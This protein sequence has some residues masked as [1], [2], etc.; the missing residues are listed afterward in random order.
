MLDGSVFFSSCRLMLAAAP[1]SLRGYAIF[2]NFTAFFSFISLVAAW[3]LQL[4]SVS[5]DS[6]KPATAI[7]FLCIIRRRKIRTAILAQAGVQFVMLAPMLAAPREMNANVVG[8][9]GADWTIS[10]CVMLHIFG[11]FITGLF[12]AYLQISERFGLTPT[13]GLGLFL[14]ATGLSVAI[15]ESNTWNIYVALALIGVGWNVV[16]VAG[17]EL[18]L[19]S[20]S[21]EERMKVTAVNE[22][23]R[24]IA[25]IISILLASSL[26]WPVLLRVCSASVIVVAFVIGS[27]PRELA[28]N[29]KPVSQPPMTHKVSTNN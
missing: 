13:M 5:P 20:H 21:H 22:C 23:L 26:A 11:M 19:R 12:T 7:S 15:L 2:F 17:T 1:A 3:G 14:Q 10:G 6:T 4:P 27:Q 9:Q 16:F 29:A 8:L 28:M 24:F 25:D 18:L